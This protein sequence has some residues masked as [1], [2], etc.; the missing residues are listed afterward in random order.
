MWPFRARGETLG[1]KGERIA[2]RYLRRAR[3][4][5]LE[6]N[7]RI[8]AYEIDLIAREGDTIVFVEV[9]TRE[10]T[11]IAAPEESVT[12]AKR[13]HIRA[14]SRRYRSMRPSPNTFYRYDIVSV[15]LPSAGKAEVTLFRDAFRDD[16]A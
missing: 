15:V 5:I 7:V 2:A 13:E 8:G 3:F 12:A 6:R 16:G 4:V 14:A 9:K 11:D 1:A 10:E